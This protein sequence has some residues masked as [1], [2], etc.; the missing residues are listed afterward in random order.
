VPGRTGA[1]GRAGPPGAPGVPGA[2][3]QTVLAE[4]CAGAPALLRPLVCH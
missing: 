2:T 4:L 1:P 3:T